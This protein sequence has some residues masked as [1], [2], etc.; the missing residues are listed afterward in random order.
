MKPFYV[1]TPIYYPN[2]RPHLGT[3]Y[4]TIAADVL[5]RYQKLRGRPARFLTG[6][7]EHGAKIARAAEAKGLS[8][9]AFTDQMQQPFRDTWELL[10]CGYDDFIRTTEPRHKQRVAALWEKIAA[11]GDIYLGEYEDWYCVGCETYY[12]EK[13]LLPGNVCPQHLRP[14]ERVKESSYFFRLG[15]YTQRLLD[16]YEAHPDFVKPAGRF[17]EVKSFVREGLRD[18]SVSRTSF[19]W[20]IPVPKDPEHVMYVWFDALTN[21]MSS[22]GGPAEP[23]TS[24]L[25]DRFWP[26]HGDVIHI[27]GKDILRFHTVY[28]PAFLLSAG[29]PPPSQIWAHGW[30]TVNGQKMSKTLG[31]F[32]PP[33]PLVEVFGVDALR[34][35]L[36][37][38]IAFGQDGD[39]SHENVLARLNGELANGLGNLLNRV[40]ISIVQK[41]L[42]ARVPAPVPSTRTADDDELEAIALRCAKQAAEHLDQVAPQRA[43][44]A[45]WEL[46][47]AGNRY[48]D[49]TE[50]WALVKRGETQR[51]EHVVYQVLETLRMVGVMIA[52]FMPGKAAD[53]RQQLGLDPLLPGEERDVWPSV[54]GGLTPGTLTRPGPPLFPRF[55]KDQAQA[56]LSRLGVQPKAADANKPKAAASGPK[57]DKRDN[58]D[59]TA[60]EP[61]AGAP[62]NDAGITY[63]DFSKV[64]LRVAAVLSAERVP[65]SDKLLKL[66]V[67]AG[68]PAPRQIIAGI[69]QHHEPETLIGKRVIIVANLKPRKLMGLESQGMVLAASDADGL[70]LTSIAGDPKPGSIVK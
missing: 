65:K 13:D 9:Q 67:D 20:G 19:R 3:A 41:N 31:N 42:G 53:L 58:V 61:T 27:V 69:G 59:K 49:R 32:L 12:T 55:D 1:T 17:N 5:T 66:S 10:N 30:L 16:Y 48:V 60:A 6:L 47:G 37:R 63:E 11:N 7:D 29:L 52:P 4:S 22:L 23:G 8:P 21:Y 50:P 68:D 18:L 43:L 39:F 25:F 24:P 57:R 44:E 15:N 2:D 35:Y 45:I 28:W 54:F 34:Y 56:A 26:P 36:M 51:L 40:L 70:Y 62:D 38:D 33:E 64:E 46:V 14:V